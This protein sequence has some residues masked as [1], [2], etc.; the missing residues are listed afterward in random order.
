MAP[1]DSHKIVA[2]SLVFSASSFSI[3]LSFPLV[4]PY[5]LLFHAILEPPNSPPNEVTGYYLCWN[6]TLIKV[7]E[8]RYGSNFVCLT[9]VLS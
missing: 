9:K 5:F 4:S 8:T 2:V 7:F 3:S 1:R 6:C